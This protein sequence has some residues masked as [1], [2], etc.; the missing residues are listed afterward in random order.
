MTSEHDHYGAPVMAAEAGHPSW[1]YVWTVVAV[2]AV[3]GF[4]GILVS[5]GGEPS[6]LLLWPFL[7][8]AAVGVERWRAGRHA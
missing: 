3:L 4:L 5:A 8:L 2:G 6:W 1:G 7:P